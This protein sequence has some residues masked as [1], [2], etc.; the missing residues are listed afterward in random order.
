MDER[1]IIESKSLWARRKKFVVSLLVVSIILTAVFAALGSVFDS[2]ADKLYA[3]HHHEEY[4]K[5]YFSGNYYWS[6]VADK[7]WDDYETKYY[8]LRRTQN[9]CNIVG[10]I[11][12][13]VL[14]LISVILLIIYLYA[15]KMQITVTD[16]R[17]YGKAAFGKRVDLPLDSISAIATGAGKGLAVAAS[18]G[19]IKFT[20]MERRDD[21]HKEISDLL[22]TRQGK[23][24]EKAEPKV[25]VK[26]SNADELKKYK[27]LLDSG[28]ITQ[29]EFDAKKKQLLGL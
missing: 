28:I 1:I 11:S 17:V 13:V 27:E 6:S 20:R 24:A 12:L 5:S 7:D 3:D 29:E 18:A 22:V 15:S 16:K 25:E 14:V 21:V 9:T 26:S 23:A 4:K 19:K 2:Q 10:S 8:E